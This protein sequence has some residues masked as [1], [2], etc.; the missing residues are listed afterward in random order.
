MS[1][2]TIKGAILIYSCHKHLENRLSN[3][4]YGLPKNEYEGWQVF[5][6]IGNPNIPERYTLDSKGGRSIITLKCEDSYLHVMK[7]VAMGIQT[8]LEL[9]DVEEGVLRC[10]DDLVFSEKRLT[11]FLNSAKKDYMGKIANPFIDESIK[12]KIDYF[13]PNYFLTRQSEIKNPMNGLLQFQMEDIMKLHEVPNVKYTGGVITYLS[14]KSCRLVVESMKNVS[15]DVFKYYPSFGY[16]YIIEDIGIGFILNVFGISPTMHDLY[17]DEEINLELAQ[18][19]I[20]CHTN[21]GK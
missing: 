19:Q 13:I 4:I 21:E 2:K 1:R 6:F 15:F 14:N 10:G 9:F 17:S 12:K 3:P 16:P 11:E 20:A 8:I 18:T 7:K 5:Y